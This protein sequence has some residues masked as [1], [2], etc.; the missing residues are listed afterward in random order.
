MT[1]KIRT[2]VQKL[3]DVRGSDD[4]HTNANRC[5]EKLRKMFTVVQKIEGR[6]VWVE[7][8]ITQNVNPSSEMASKLRPLE[9]KRAA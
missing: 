1:S 6:M 7:I 2:V 5:V 4:R 9:Q 3:K 8:V